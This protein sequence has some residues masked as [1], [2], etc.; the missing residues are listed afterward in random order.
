MAKFT[1]SEIKK[2]KKDWGQTHSEVC[3]ELG[4]DEDSSDDLLIDDFFWS[5]TD[6]LWLNK[7]ASGFTERETEI[8]DY[9]QHG[10]EEEENEE[11]K[12]ELK[13]EEKIYDVY[14]ND[15]AYKITQIFDYEKGDTEFTVH[16]YDTACNE[17]YPLD[18][19]FAT[20]AK[21]RQDVLL[22][23]TINAD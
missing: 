15:S 2:F 1:E 10:E 12:I 23:F 19:T 3:S 22:Y 13:F 11:N 14:Y 7:E 8:A 17:S 20:D 16:K 9:L 6:E 18:G 5:E 21:E 4:Y